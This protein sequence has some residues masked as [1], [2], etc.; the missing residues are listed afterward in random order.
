MAANQACASARLPVLVGAT[1]PYAWLLPCAGLVPRRR[2]F[3]LQGELGTTKHDRSAL[4]TRSPCIARVLDDKDEEA[5]DD[6]DILDEKDLQ[7]CVTCEIVCSR[8]GAQIV[9]PVS[10]E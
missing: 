3:Q 5:M 8:N 10:I 7:S 2:P 9:Q 4:W 6:D 1:S